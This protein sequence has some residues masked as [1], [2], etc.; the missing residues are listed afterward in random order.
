MKLSCIIPIVLIAV[1]LLLFGCVQNGKTGDAEG[2]LAS[3][4][5][6]GT[7]SSASDITAENVSDI[8]TSIDATA[9]A[10]EGFEDTELEELPIDETTFQ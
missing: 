8:G 3:A 6:E 2:V 1:L 10:I 9:D 4:Q 7:G 5:L